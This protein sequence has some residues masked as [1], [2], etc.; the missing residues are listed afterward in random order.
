MMSPEAQSAF[1]ECGVFY[2]DTVLPRKLLELYQVG[3]LFRE[4]TFCDST[5]KFG[6]LAA[7][8]RYLIIS[9]NARCIDPI[10]LH[11]EWGLCIWQTDRIFKVIANQKSADFTQVTLLEVPEALRQEFTTEHLSEMEQRFAQQA[12]RQFSAALQTQALPEHK[13]RLWL[14]RL[15]LPVGIDDNGQFFE[16]WRYGT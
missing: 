8:H 10:S 7:T 3:L 9:A 13:T 4:P 1:A 2:R 16:S 5:Y 11:P 6:G 14:D 12:T 15:E